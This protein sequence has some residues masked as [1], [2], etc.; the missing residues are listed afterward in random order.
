MKGYK[1]VLK[2]A[3]D[4]IEIAEKKLSNLKK[5]KLLEY[6]R[7]IAAAREF[8]IAVLEKEMLD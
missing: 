1:I 2:N 5:E 7:V 6:Y 3:E 8:G 4:C